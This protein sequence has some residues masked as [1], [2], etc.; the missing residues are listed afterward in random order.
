M[1]RTP[2]IASIRVVAIRRN[3]AIRQKTPFIISVNIEIIPV[4][5][6]KDPARNNGVLS[7]IGLNTPTAHTSGSTNRNL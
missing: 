5:T 1:R 7:K 6:V 3:D 4:V 2:H